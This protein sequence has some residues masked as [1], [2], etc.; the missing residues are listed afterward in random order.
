MREAGNAREVWFSAVPG[1]FE[2][3]SAFLERE[4]RIARSSP[5]NRKS[6]RG[7]LALPSTA[8]TQRMEASAGGSFEP[9]DE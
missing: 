7:Q 3:E 1:E 6:K 4:T 9:A 5:E 8:K 2:R